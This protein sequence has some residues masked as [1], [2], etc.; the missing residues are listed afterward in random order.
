MRKLFAVI[1]VLSMLAALGSSVY[2]E[3]VN[4]AKEG[5]IYDSSSK[6]EEVEGEETPADPAAMLIDGSLDTK[7]EVLY[8]DSVVPDD[9]I[10]YSHYATIDLGELKNVTGYTLYNASEGSAD[11]GKTEYDAKAW[12]VQVS[13]DAF[14]WTDVDTV[15]DNTTA[16]YEK[17]FDQTYQTRFVR[18]LVEYPAQDEK[19]LTVRLPEF[20]I[21]GS[22]IEKVATGYR[23]VALNGTV[24]ETSGYINESESA[25]LLI[26]GSLD[27]KWCAGL[28]NSEMS[29]E[30][31]DVCYHFATVD[32]GS[33]CKID[34]YVLKNASIGSRDLG[35]TQYDTYA[36]ILEAS[37]DNQTWK[38]V[39][40]VYGNV[41]AEYTYELSSPVEARYFRLLVVEPE[42]GGG[43]TTR[44]Y[45]LELWGDNV[46]PAEP[47]VE[48]T[49]APAAEETVAEAE[50]VAEEAAAE[51]TATAPET[52]DPSVLTAVAAVIASVGAVFGYSRKKK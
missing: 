22:D 28:D 13:G 29:D 42:Q 33:V 52:A 40:N 43:T 1:A 51:E 16:K 46:A 18:I 39:D 38:E 8:D 49:A 32:L 5:K 12:T 10:V 25:A 19:D 47:V 21:Y 30:L 34:K 37:D 41:E 24:I 17:K 45:E 6:P 50:T 48:E 9:L 4:L 36:W 7:W 23:N 3:D 15:T 2:A 26:D 11:K 44:I 31:W 35:Q 14:T 20:E 27:T